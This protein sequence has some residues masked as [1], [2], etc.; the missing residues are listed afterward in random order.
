MLEFSTPRESPEIIFL[1]EVVP[2]SLAM[3]QERLQSEYH[4]F[5]GGKMAYFTSMLL[6][7]KDFVLKTVMVEP[8]PNS[9]M[10]RNLT[11][12]KVSCC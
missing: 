3:I 9:A 8:F 10:L 4:I 12:A 1:Q 11:V 7:K 6:K 5:P 2:E